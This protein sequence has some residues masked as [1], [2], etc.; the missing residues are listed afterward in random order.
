[1]TDNVT[2][3]RGR[4]AGSKNV[5]KKPAQPKKKP[6]SQAKE[7]RTIKRSAMKEDIP[8][9]KKIEYKR[10]TPLEFALEVMNDETQEPARR[11]K[12]AVA[13][14]PYM[15]YKKGEGGKREAVEDN[16]KEAAKGKFA[17]SAPPQLVINNK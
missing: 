4:P 16:A 14:L 17:P 11:D 6:L 5:A 12:M 1:M 7:L 2:K 8:E 10:M 13:C 3:K 15:H 9:E